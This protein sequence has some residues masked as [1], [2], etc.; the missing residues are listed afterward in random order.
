[1]VNEENI[2]RLVSFEVIMISGLRRIGVV[3]WCHT[4]VSHL[5]WTHRG[6]VFPPMIAPN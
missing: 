6:A 5:Y 1:M 2:I 3:I 4:S